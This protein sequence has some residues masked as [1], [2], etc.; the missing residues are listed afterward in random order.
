MSDEGFDQHT[1][2]AVV[3]THEHWH[4]THNWSQNAHTSSTWRRSTPTRTTTP[5]RALALPAPGL[6]GRAQ[7]RGARAL[8]RRPGRR[9]A[10]R[11]RTPPR[12]TA[13]KVDRQEG[14]RRRRRRRRRRRPRRRQRRSRP[15]RRPD[16]LSL[17]ASGYW[18]SRLS[19]CVSS[20]PAFS[21][22]DLQRLGVLGRVDL[23]GS[24]GLRARPRP[25]APA[26]MNC[27]INCCLSISMV[28]PVPLSWRRQQRPIVGSAR[29]DIRIRR[30]H[31][32]R[33]AGRR[34]LHR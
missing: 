16:G 29:H 26:A 10:G 2:E 22:S 18:S 32:G 25:A 5:A 19:D 34:R 20:R 8:S 23:S 27:S 15:P 6:R 17:D 28:S 11:R 4:V 31:R 1:H 14:H 9:G 12:T 24:P 33:D 7:R 3:H 21:P 13:K 30:R